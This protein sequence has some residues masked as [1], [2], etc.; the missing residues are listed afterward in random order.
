MHSSTHND[1]YNGFFFLCQEK[2]PFFLYFSVFFLYIRYNPLRRSSSSAIISCLHRGITVFASPPVATAFA[3]HP[4]SSLILSISPSIID[5][6]PKRIPL[7]IQSTVFFPIVFAGASS[8]IL[9]SC[10]VLLTR[11]S[12]ETLR[13]GI[14]IPP[15]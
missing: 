6:L 2:K 11:D 4:I 14:I 8:P 7:F 3:S 9:G 10:D 1:I 12:R 13:P 15:I 5:A